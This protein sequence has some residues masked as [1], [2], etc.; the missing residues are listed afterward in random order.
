MHLSALKLCLI[1]HPHSSSSEDYES[2]ICQAIKGGVTAIQLRNKKNS[3]AAI[4]DIAI[5]LLSIMCPLGIPLIINDNVRLAK[6]THAAG[7]H[8]GQSDLSPLQARQYL[9]SD[10][11][12]GWSIETLEQLEHANQLDCIDYVAAS[13]VF[14]STTKHDCKTIWGLTGLKTI[15]QQSRHPVVAIGGIN[16][17]NIRDVMAQGAHGAAVVSAI[18]NHAHPDIAAA[19]LIREINQGN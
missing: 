19:E 15:T 18:H 17:L 11:I 12:I 13:A 3:E 4:Y 5:R 16:I 8:L 2:F 6:D 1:T 14:P 9:G 10:K 7:V